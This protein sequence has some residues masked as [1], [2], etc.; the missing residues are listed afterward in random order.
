MHTFESF[1]L[2]FFRK[3]LWYNITVEQGKWMSCRARK[4]NETLVGV[5]QCEISG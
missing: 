5:L 2:T 1:L 3:Y 4:V